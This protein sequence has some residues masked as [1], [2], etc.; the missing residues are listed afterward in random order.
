[1]R[2]W[3]KVHLKE[4]NRHVELISKSLTNYLYGFVKSII[5]IL[6]IGRF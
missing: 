1:M 6:M 4:Q 2:V 5:L 3:S